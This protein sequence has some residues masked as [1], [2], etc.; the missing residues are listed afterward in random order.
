[1]AA[2][3][4]GEVNKLFLGNLKTTVLSFFTNK[5]RKKLILKITI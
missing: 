3:S 4:E 2:V 5:Q 1:M